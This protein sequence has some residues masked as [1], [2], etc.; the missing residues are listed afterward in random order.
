MVLNRL[1][2]ALSYCIASTVEKGCPE[3]ACIS[4]CCQEIVRILNNN[5]K[6]QQQ[7]FIPIKY[8]IYTQKSIYI[9]RFIII[10]ACATKGA[11]STI[12][13][14]CARH[15]ASYAVLGFPGENIGHK[16]VV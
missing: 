6:A 10:S 7:P 13:D 15:M 8:Y 11:G 4:L 5:H 14:M 3:I 12:A 9:N 1:H 2:V 16:P